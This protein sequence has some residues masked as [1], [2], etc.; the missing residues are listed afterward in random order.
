ML[1][2]FLLPTG[3]LTA[4][5]PVPAKVHHYAQRLIQRYDRNG[6]GQLQEE[7]WQRMRGQPAR[8]DA[9]GDGVVTLDELTQWI[10]AFGAQRKL[11]LV[12]AVAGET[13]SAD[14]PSGEEAKTDD[15]PG[16]PSEQAKPSSEA[17][18]PP[19]QAGA[20]APVRQGRFHVSAKRLPP[21]LPPWFLQRDANGDG[22]IT[23]S[24]FA[25][26]ATAEDRREFSRYDR[27]GDGVITPQ[28]C[29][30]NAAPAKAKAKA[31]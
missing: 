2:P 19:Q 11:R 18:A 31:P 25:P 23:L 13:A 20:K 21:G 5:T 22:Q 17:S 3:H 8:M 4:Q 16:A 29:T 7:E 15:D 27:N 14:R 26:K 28:E 10:V 30:K 1:S 24:E 12:Q 9:N 6:D